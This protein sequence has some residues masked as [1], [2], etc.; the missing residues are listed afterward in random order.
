MELDKFTV[1]EN[2]KKMEVIIP[3]TGDRS[4]DNY[5]KEAEIEK[6]KDQLRKKPDKVKSHSNE[7]IKGALREYNDWKNK[8]DSGQTRKYY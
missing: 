2:G 5:L 3:K 7:E 4:Y 8:R 6:T 1:E